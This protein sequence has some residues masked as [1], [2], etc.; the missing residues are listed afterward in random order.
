MVAV[1]AGS[2][3]EEAWL[4]AKALMAA[5]P[6]ARPGGWLSQQAVSFTTH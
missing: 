5:R 3:A 6:G 2:V 4:V 1:E